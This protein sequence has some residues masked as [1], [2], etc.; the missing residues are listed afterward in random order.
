MHI[1]ASTLQRRLAVEGT[2]FQSLKDQLRRD[3]AIERLSTSSTPV[4]Q[5]AAQ[6][7]FAD[8]TAFNRAFKVWTGST[9]GSY[10]RR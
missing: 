3:L 8:T 2:S 1:S 6:L 10:R 9:P 5:L 4:S 7:G